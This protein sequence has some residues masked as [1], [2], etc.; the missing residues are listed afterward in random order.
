MIEHTPGPW[1]IEPA[2]SEYHDISIIGRGP[3]VS[4]TIA[5]LHSKWAHESQ[6]LEQQANARLIAAVPDMFASLTELVNSPNAKQN[7]M[8]DRARAAIAKGKP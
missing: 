3:V 6:E 7:A 1:T 2:D 4:G 8:W 5:Q